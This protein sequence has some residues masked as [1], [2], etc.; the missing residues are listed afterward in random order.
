MGDGYLMTERCVC[1]DSISRWRAIPVKPVLTCSLFF[2]LYKAKRQQSGRDTTMI[3]F[4]NGCSPTLGLTPMNRW[5]DA[6][7]AA[8]ERFRDFLMLLCRLQ[9]RLPKRS[10]RQLLDEPT[11]WGS[12]P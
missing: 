7:S 11:A 9:I 8:L 4:P 12:R 3:A 5:L 10:L 2:S 6:D 1:S